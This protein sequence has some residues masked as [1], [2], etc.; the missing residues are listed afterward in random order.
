M[1][2][3]AARRHTLLRR[4]HCRLRRS[5]PPTENARFQF[6]LLSATGQQDWRPT[7][8]CFHRGSVLQCI[9]GAMQGWKLEVSRVFRCFI[10]PAIV[11][12][13][14]ACSHAASRA[15]S[16]RVSAAP[17]AITVMAAVAY[18]VGS[19][20]SIGVDPAGVCKQDP[21]ACPQLDLTSTSSPLTRAAPLPQPVSWISRWFCPFQFPQ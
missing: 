7:T 10:V 2:S 5:G 1:R 21:E 9:F 6:R 14:P 18:E 19:D 20:P 16:A 3:E 11:T 15:R 17:Q 4:T 13:V 12:F 8:F